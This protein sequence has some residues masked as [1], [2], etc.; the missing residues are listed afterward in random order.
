MRVRR[1]LA[2]GLGVAV[3]AGGGVALA[4]VGVDLTA[5]GPQPATVTV[6]WGETVVFSNRDSEAHAIEV[7]RETFT[8]E[9]IPPGGTL[10]YVFDGRAGVYIVRQL[11]SRVQQGRVVVEVDGTVTLTAKESIR[12]GKPLVVSGTS[13][14]A[15]S[16]VSLVRAVPDDPG[17]WEEVATAEVGEDGKFMLRLELEVGGRFRAGGRSRADPLDS[18]PGRRPAQDHARRFRSLGR[19]RPA[20]RDHREDRPRWSGEDRL[21]RGVRRWSETLAA[22]AVGAR[23]RLRGRDLPAPVR[24]S[25]KGP[26]AH[27]DAPAVGARLRVRRDV[28]PVDLDRRQLAVRSGSA[29]S[30][31]ARLVLNA[32]D[33]GAS[34]ETVR[35]D[36]RLHRARGNRPARRSCREPRR[37]TRRSRSPARGQTSASACT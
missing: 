2:V 33:F 27:R 19:R 10:E 14:V 5:T 18:D 26:G 31:V 22:G 37:P 17:T 24:G 35:V 25:R 28:E 3:L 8:S 16:A 9:A 11:G 29:R 15:G 32:D 36:H 7:P 20:R 30:L 6:R 12:Y 21:A 13:T 1:L 23:R 4:A 34:A